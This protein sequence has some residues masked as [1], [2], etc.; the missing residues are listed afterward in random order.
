[1]TLNYFI[2]LFTGN[3]SFGSHELVDYKAYC[4]ANNYLLDGQNDCLIDAYNNIAQ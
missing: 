2:T 1:M 3:G 4:A